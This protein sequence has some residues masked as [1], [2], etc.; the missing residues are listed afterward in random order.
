[1]LPML[2][3]DNLAMAPVVT[4]PINR[5]GSFFDGF[6]GDDGGFASRA[7]S[8]APVA[9][10]EDDNQIHIEV[11]LPGV[12]EQDIEVMVDNGKLF[13]RGE[14]KAEEGRRYLVN[15][16]SFGQFEQVIT[17]PEAVDSEGVNATLTNG[18]L[19]IDLPKSPEARP[20]RIMLRTE[21]K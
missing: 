3:N 13:I 5:L 6:F 2:R 18:V 1:M 10:W 20:R 17:L 12:S 9:M 21:E 11:E 15:N 7:W 8:W 16:R 19:G 4:S 14:R